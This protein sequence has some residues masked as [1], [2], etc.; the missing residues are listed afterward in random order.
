MYVVLAEAVWF[1]SLR[2]AVPVGAPV[3]GVIRDS[4]ISWIGSACACSGTNCTWINFSMETLVTHS[5]D[6]V[7]AVCALLHED[8][9][10]FGT[11]IPRRHGHGGRIANLEGVGTQCV[12]ASFGLRK[13]WCWCTVCNSVLWSSQRYPMMAWMV[14]NWIR[15][16]RGSLPRAKVQ[17]I[18]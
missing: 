11:F 16:R 9:S 5:L 12:L 10:L 7:N 1:N 14:C 13:G 6:G 4:I 2:E 15:W 3:L 18:F 17:D 8:R